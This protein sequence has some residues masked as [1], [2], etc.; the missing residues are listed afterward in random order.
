VRLDVS[1]TRQS[2][3]VDLPVELIDLGPRQRRIDPAKVSNLRVSMRENSFFGAVV[4]RPYAGPEGTR[5]QLVGGA[6]RLTAWR[7][8]GGVT[9]PAHIMA[10]SDDEALQ[11][12]I[13]EN[14]VRSDLTP[15]ERAE[16]VAARFKV[17]ARRFPER[18]LVEDGQLKPKKG[19][20]GNGANIAQF[21]SGAPATMGF[22]AATAADVGLSERTIKASW[23]TV[24][25]LPAALRAKLAGTWIGKSEGVLRQLAGIPDPGE[26]A[27]VVEVLLSGKTTKL[28]DAR[29]IANGKAPFKAVQT[30][31]DVV[32][33][34][35]K[36]LWRKASPS[37]R[38]AI[39]D[40]LEGERLP[41]G[42]QV[43]NTAPKEV[44]HG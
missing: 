27:A 4:V 36:A 12:E 42:F 9:I 14:L 22:A 8:E 16:A 34:T 23:A 7:E 21:Q 37:A 19:R 25:G 29:A 30:P 44:T 2:Q 28:H 18:V 17:W 38:T 39:L 13:D 15:L 41:R 33:N 24:N 40:F 1:D 10:L 3:A 26:Q 5:Y 11:I 20:P 43:S 32:L 35:F 6:H 31:V